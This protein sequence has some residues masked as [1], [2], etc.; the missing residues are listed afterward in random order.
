M[1]SQQLI[2][3]FEYERLYHEG[4]KGGQLTTSQFEALVQYNQAHDNRFFTVIH[5]GIKF[6]QYV[7]VI[8]VGKLTIE[9]LPKADRHSFSDADR[10]QWHE[11]LF[12]MLRACRLLRLEESSDADLRIRHAALHDLYIQQFLWEVEQLVH[13]GLTKQYRQKESNRNVLTGRLEFQEHLSRNLVHKER[14][15]VRHQVYDLIHVLHEIINEALLIIPLVSTN[16]NLADRVARLRLSFPETQHRKITKSLF[17]GLTYGRKTEHYRRAIELARLL[18]LNYSPDI[19]KGLNP[20]LAILFDMN[21]L[22]EEYI[23][24]QVKK[25]AGSFGFEV[26][27]QKRKQFWE[28]KLIKPDI[29]IQKESDTYVLDTKWKVLKE[30]KPS[31]TDLK[32]MYAYHHYW[33]AKR[34]YLLYPNVYNLTPRKGSYHIPKECDFQ[35]QMRFVDVLAAD[36]KLNGGVGEGILSL[37]EER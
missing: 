3:V 8:Q 14:F 6:K 17:D 19:R 4:R 18:L 27:R 30:A 13:K 26:R 15:F 36:G 21:E 16:P 7:G 24:R 22:F 5:Q 9:I 32:Q 20:V 29:V 37:L 28:K 1:A 11:V 2:Q 23:Y 10:G 33:K 31:D 12:Q 25:R 34:T 35:C